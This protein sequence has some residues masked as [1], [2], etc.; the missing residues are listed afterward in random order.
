[1]RGRST[2][3]WHRNRHER[4]L[5]PGELWEKRLGHPHGPEGVHPEG[6]LPV[7]VT[8]TADRIFSPAL[9]GDGLVSKRWK[10]LVRSANTMM[11]GL[12]VSRAD[13]FPAGP[14]SGHQ[15]FKR[16]DR[17][18]RVAPVQGLGQGVRPH[19]CT[20]SAC[21]T[22]GHESYARP[23]AAQVMARRQAA[24]AGGSRR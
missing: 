2:A 22:P 7:L 6:L 19:C 1:V 4:T 20:P 11:A 23:L 18:G 9:E 13:A 8:D 5:A 10:T 12:E 15:A 21:R 16:Q 3:A 24:A 17:R 14:A